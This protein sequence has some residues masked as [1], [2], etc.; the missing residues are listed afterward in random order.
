[1]FSDA[2][3]TILA[4]LPRGTADGGNS[5]DVTPQKNLRSVRFLKS[6]GRFPGSGPRLESRERSGD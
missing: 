4:V 3:K 1:M 2:S 6:V 5:N